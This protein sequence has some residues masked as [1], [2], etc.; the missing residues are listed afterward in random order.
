MKTCPKCRAEVS[1]SAVLCDCGHRFSAAEAS[2]LPAPEDDTT[3]PERRP[4]RFLLIVISLF[5]I[6]GF[7]RRFFFPPGPEEE[8]PSPTVTLLSIA[9]QVAMIIGVIGL[10][11]RRLKA[12]ARPAE[13]VGAWMVLPVLGLIAEFG[14]LAIRFSGGPPGELPQRPGTS[15]DASRPPSMREFQMERATPREPSADDLAL[16]REALDAGEQRDYDQAIAKYSEL[17]RRHP[18]LK[19]A[20]YNRGRAYEAKGDYAKAIEDYNEAI[21]LDPQYAVAYHNR[22]NVYAYD[23]QGDSRAMAD[24]DRA[25]QLNPTSSAYGDRANAYRGKGD[26]EKSLSDSNESVRLNPRN[27][28]AYF[29]RGHTYEAILEYDKA[30]ADYNRALELDS[31]M[32]G[33]YFNRAGIYYETKRDYAKA[34]ADYKEAV[35]ADAEFADAYNAAAWLLA[36]CPQSKYRDGKKAVEFANK[37]CELSEWKDPNYVDTLAAAY[38]EAGDFPQAIKWA[39]QYLESPNLAE[40]DITEGKSRLALYRAG[41]PYH[42]KD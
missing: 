7:A 24:Y 15:A 20:Y 16:I 41:K 1:P 5:L 6:S 2:R 8:W 33:V 10:S 23:L 28:Q 13:A 14:L 19:E 36:T 32:A 31:N 12:T 22:A 3:G 18:T 9:S 25:I 17:I 21:R 35:R 30:L 29:G 27:A 11:F 38:A 40:K 37:A 39:Q 34:I 4:E 42:R 26:Y